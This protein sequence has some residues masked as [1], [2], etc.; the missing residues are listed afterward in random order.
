MRR[1]T[2]QF[3]LAA[4]ITYYGLTLRY[5]RARRAQGKLLCLRARLTDHFAELGDARVHY[6]HGGKIGSHPLVM[7][8]ALTGNSLDTFYDQIRPLAKSH[9][10]VIPDLVWYG[11]STSS[12]EDYSIDFQARTIMGLVDSLGIERFSVLGPCFGGYVAFRMADCYPNRV[13]KLVISDCPVGCEHTPETFDQLMKAEGYRAMLDLNPPQS[14]D[15]VRRMN[16]LAY[17]KL[18]RVPEGAWKQWH[19][20]AFSKNLVQRKGLVEYVGEMLKGR[21]PE[22]NRVQDPWSMDTLLIWGRYDTVYPLEVEGD[23]SAR[24]LGDKAEVRVIE[25]TAHNPWMERPREFNRLVE[26]FLDRDG[27]GAHRS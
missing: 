12:K 8:M 1:I 6:W 27:G 7:I 23:R 2:T 20:R 22:A 21:T 3:K 24:A 14:P 13:R 9:E 15:D 26:E 25:E 18:P 17:Y 10:L 16:E 5:Y 4:Q 11:K 19:A